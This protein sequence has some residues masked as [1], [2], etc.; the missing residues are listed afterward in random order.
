M[1]FK[2][3]VWDDLE[4][5]RFLQPDD[6]PD[7]I[8]D[9]KIYL[10][11]DFCWPIKLISDKQI[12]GVGAAIAFKNTGWLA[13]I[14]VDSNYRNRG[15]G[16]KITG[17]LKRILAAQ[18]LSN[19]LLLASELGKPVYLR[20][21]FRVVGE[22]L[23]MQR[24]SDPKPFITSKSII[25]FNQKYRSSVLELDRAITGEN[26]TELLLSKIN[27]SH[28]YIKGEE[29]M[30]FYIPELCEGPIIAQDDTAGIELM[31]VKYASAEKAVLPLDNKAGK[32]FLINNGFSDTGKKGT[33]MILGEEVNWQPEKIFSRIGGNFG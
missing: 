3:L 13:H 15:L 30:G 32:D 6:W 23:Y 7:I 29:L 25:P 22:Y 8:I 14:I 26:R 27:S 1:N 17:E 19:L 24:K 31:K 21:G 18:G 33:R 2:P 11:Y 4:K 28:L 16:G 9:F 5:I 10:H 12:I 20:A